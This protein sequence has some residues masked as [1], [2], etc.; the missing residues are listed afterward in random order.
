MTRTPPSECP[1]VAARH[2]VPAISRLLNDVDPSRPSAPP[3]PHALTAPS[4]PA[5][6]RRLPRPALLRLPLVASSR[7]PPQA[8]RPQSERTTSMSAGRDRRPPTKPAVCGWSLDGRV[9]I[10]MDETEQRL[11]HDERRRRAA[12]IR[13][14]AIASRRPAKTLAT[15]PRQA[16]R[17]RPPRRS[18][19]RECGAGR[20]VRATSEGLA[21]NECERLGHGHGCISQAKHRSSCCGSTGGGRSAPACALRLIARPL[22][23]GPS[24]RGPRAAGHGSETC[25][26]ARGRCSHRTRSAAERSRSAARR[27]CP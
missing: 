6:A 9:A 18:Q 2:H 4:P 25:R 8:L 14:N 24:S 7:P 23:T 20:V 16:S 5:G 13:A 21:R 12:P 19:P 10:G 27:P 11:D 17:S 3:R 22:C 1:G 15:R 26:G